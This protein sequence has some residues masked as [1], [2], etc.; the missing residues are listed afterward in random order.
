MEANSI[1]G[2]QSMPKDRNMKF[3][4]LVASCESVRHVPVLWFIHKYSKIHDVTQ[5][6]NKI[7]CKGKPDCPYC[8]NENSK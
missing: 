2:R 5:E 8:P 4:C 1:E 6:E 3:H 7:W